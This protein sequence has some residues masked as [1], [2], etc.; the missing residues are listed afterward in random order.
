MIYHNTVRGDI[1]NFMS[2]GELIDDSWSLSLDMTN[3]TGS[4]TADPSPFLGT[5]EGDEGMLGNWQGLFAGPA[6]DANAAAVRPSGIAGAFTGSFTNG[7]DA[8]AF[9]ATLDADE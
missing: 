5:T 4:T 2:G 9:G 3:F 6:T 7:N 8:G 1:E